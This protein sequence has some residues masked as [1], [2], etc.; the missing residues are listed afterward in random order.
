M[1]R[2]RFLSRLAIDAWT[3]EHVARLVAEGLPGA[4]HPLGGVLGVA[5][6]HLPTAQM[7]L[8]EEL[9]QGSLLT[10]LAANSFA[11]MDRCCD[12]PYSSDG[13]ISGPTPRLRGGGSMGGLDPA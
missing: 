8:E 9:Q 1:D 11:S 13:S 2:W 6:R 3:P 5:R 12:G 4:D 7:A 10:L